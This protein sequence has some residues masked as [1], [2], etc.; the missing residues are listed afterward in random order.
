MKKSTFLSVLGVGSIFC[1]GM[2]LSGCGGTTTVTSISVT[3]LPATE[4]VVGNYLNLDGGKFTVVQD[5]GKKLELDLGLASVD[6]R[7]L[8]EVGVKVVTVTYAEKSTSFEVV[9]KKANFNPQNISSAYTIYNGQPQEINPLIHVPLSEG[10]SI[11]SVMYKEKNGTTYSENAPVN[12]GW[13]MAKVHLLGGSRYE[14]CDVLINYFIREAEFYQFANENVFA[15]A[16]ECCATY[17]TDIDVSQLWIQSSL[18]NENKIFNLNSSQNLL[19]PVT[20]NDDDFAVRYECKDEKGNLMYIDSETNKV[21]KNEDLEPLDVGNYT[22]G[23]YCT[24]STLNFNSYSKQNKLSIKAKQLE[25]GVDFKVMLNYNSTLGA[26]SKELVITA[27]NTLAGEYTNVTG[28]FQISVTS[29][30]EL[31]TTEELSFELEYGPMPAPNAPQTTNVVVLG[32]EKTGLYRFYLVSSNKNINY[33]GNVIFSV[34]FS[35]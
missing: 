32:V 14:D 31:F 1:G 35:E 21:Y 25:L 23:T 2:L 13:Y 18:T 5:N 34:I 17:G 26:Q 3:T 8:D 29:L 28:N 10:M 20:Y 22:I 16:G 33:N 11:E 12:V 24:S 6:T 19:G 9:V 30:S 4:Y 15:Y 27:G 7:L